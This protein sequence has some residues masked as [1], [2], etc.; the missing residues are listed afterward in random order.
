VESKFIVAETHR[1]AESSVATPRGSRS[2][3][4]AVAEV[5]SW[6]TYINKVVVEVC[7][8]QGS[9]KAIKLRAH[10]MEI[11]HII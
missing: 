6:M 11:V 5:G 2:S 1:G 10:Q 9:Y 7:S 3:H 4:F 8:F